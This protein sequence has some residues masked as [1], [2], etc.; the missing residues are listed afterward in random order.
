MPRRT[1]FISQVRSVLRQ[2]GL[3]VPSGGAQT[4]VARAQTLSLPDFLEGTLELLEDVTERIRACDE[5]LRGIV[6]DDEVVQRLCTVPGVGPVTAVSFVATIDRVERFESARP[7][8][9]SLGAPT[10]GWCLAST[11]RPSANQQPKAIAANTTM[12]EKSETRVRM[13]EDDGVRG[14]EPSLGVGSCSREGVARWGH[15]GLCAFDEHSRL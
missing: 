12:D 1:R 14:G 8:R 7:P 4:F 9:S 10:W 15:V 13:T 11:A 3:R 5:R 6:R 2:Y